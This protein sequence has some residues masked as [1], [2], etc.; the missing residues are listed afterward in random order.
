MTPR[1]KNALKQLTCIS[2]GFVTLHAKGSSNVLEVGQRQQQSGFLQQTS[3][4]F[5]APRD[6]S[7][8]SGS[9]SKC[10][11]SSTANKIHGEGVLIY[12]RSGSIKKHIHSSQKSDT[13]IMGNC[14]AIFLCPNLSLTQSIERRLCI[15][16]SAVW[17]N[18]Q[19]SNCLGWCQ[20]TL[21]G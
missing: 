11:S 10:S 2:T 16:T 20:Q 8:L 7:H 4:H 15:T 17:R 18:F 12:Q 1:D 13:M 14:G 5:L 19:R 3:Q 6:A 21:Q 9:M